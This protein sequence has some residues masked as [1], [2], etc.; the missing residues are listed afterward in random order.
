MAGM[1][2]GIPLF[3]LQGPRLTDFVIEEDPRGTMI[4]LIGL[5]VVIAIIIV[6]NIARGGASSSV[7]GTGKSRGR[8]QVSARRFSAFTLYRIASAYGLDK[9]QRKLLEYVFRNDGVV[10]PERV[11]GNI[12][13]M[14]RHFKRA[15]RSIEK[16]SETDDDA[17]ER[18]SKLFSLRNEIE[19]SSGSTNSAAPRLAENTPAV[20]AIEKDSYPVKV[21]SSRGQ[22]VVTEIPR[23]SLGSPIRII[24]G[25][26]VTLSFF[27]KSSSGFS[28]SGQVVGSLTTDRGQ[29][30]Q[31][32]H[33]GK[34]KRLVKRM[35]RR[36]QVSISCDL[37]LVNLVESY[38]KKTP[39]KLIVDSRKFSGTILD[40]SAGGCALKA[41][42][43]IPVGSR[44]KISIDYDERHIIHVLGQILRANRSGVSG[45]ILHV[46]FLKVPRRAFNAI[47]A[48]V[49]GYND[50]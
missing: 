44:L 47:S 2:F 38:D 28:L 32:S 39:P 50:V 33:T 19:S 45:T 22:N 40:I 11:M 13:L 5:G 26:K 1:F 6:A 21:I 18:L 34:L 8:E 15:Y 24:K 14:D 35:Y 9:G 7:M 29:G 20:L 43:P 49:Y 31:I 23:N 16:R 4:A 37:S 10:D 36:K 17:Q 25:A 41:S 12:P 30:L 46:K 27:T 48:T 42:A 3:L